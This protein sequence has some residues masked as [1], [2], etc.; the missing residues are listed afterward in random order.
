MK[1]INEYIIEKLHLNKDIEVKNNNNVIVTEAIYNYLTEALHYEVFKDYIC[2]NK[3]D[4]VIEIEFIFPQDKFSFN[5]MCD[6]LKRKIMEKLSIIKSVSSNFTN[7]RD[8][9]ILV[10]YEKD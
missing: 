5:S 4:D 6:F 8:K 2:K 3:E 10:K 7:D 1:K 9:I